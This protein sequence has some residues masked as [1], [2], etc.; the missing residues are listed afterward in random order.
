MLASITL[1][2]LEFVLAALAVVAV[3]VWIFGGRWRR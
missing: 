3:L 1:H 2:D